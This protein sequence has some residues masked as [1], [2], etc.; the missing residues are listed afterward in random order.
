MVPDVVGL[1][2]E[3]E[4][5]PFV[6]GNGLEQA[7]VPILIAGLMDEVA[8]ALGVEGT[9]GRRGKDWRSIR[10]RGGEPLP[11]WTKSPNNLR[12]AVYHP[13]LAVASAS[14]V[15][16]LAH[17]GI[18][19]VRRDDAAR[20]TRLELRDAADLPSA[21][22]LA[23]ETFLSPEERQLVEIVDDNDVAC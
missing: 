10:V 20:Q 12:V 17:A 11:S 23:R 7:H 4:A 13:E 6:D 2:T 3:L 14:P 8:N 9:S 22:G 1:G 5:E 18:V 21:E 16:I 19:H 15:G